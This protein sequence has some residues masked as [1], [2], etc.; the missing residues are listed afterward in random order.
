MDVDAIKT[1]I[2][3]RRNNS[4][5]LIEAQGRLQTVVADNTKLDNNFKT[6]LSEKRVKLE[7]LYKEGRHY[8]GSWPIVYTDVQIEKYPYYGGA[9]DDLCNPYFRKTA[10][11]A[12]DPGIE[13]ILAPITRTLPATYNRVRASI[14]E[15]TYSSPALTALN[16]YPDHTYEILGMSYSCVGASGSTETECLT[17][18]GVWTPTPPV[19]NPAQ[20]ATGLL[21]AA[22]LPWKADIEIIIA[23]VFESAPT[24]SFWQ[25][26]L[27]EVNNCLSLLPPEATYPDQTPNPTGALLSSINALKAY[28]GTTIPSTVSARLSSINS[29]TASEEQAFFNIIKLRLHFVNGSFTKMKVAANQLTMNSSL[30]LD[31][32]QAIQSLTAMLIN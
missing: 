24:L 8:S 10:V 12:G 23:D 20:T 31:N 6:S 3:K 32:K 30:V 25:G 13:P 18:G 16:A 14:K 7:G 2:E 21:K 29:L 11:D 4:A 1:E 15:D 27:S 5:A 22:L 9:T 17:N 26:V 28:A 19:W